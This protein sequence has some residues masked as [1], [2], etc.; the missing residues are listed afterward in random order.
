MPRGTVRFYKPSGRSGYGFIAPD[1]GSVRV[2][3]AGKTAFGKSISK[4]DHVEFEYGNYRPGK[5]PA[6]MKLTANDDSDDSREKIET[7]YGEYDY[8]PFQ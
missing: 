3:F 8:E 7:I 4:G 5:G 1:D 6:A 2:Y